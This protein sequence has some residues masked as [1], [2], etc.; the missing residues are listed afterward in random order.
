MRIEKDDL[1]EAANAGLISDE[2]AIR[3]WAF[4]S[5]MQEDIP[6]FQLAHV[7][8]YFG[9]LLA[10]TA[11]TLFVTQAW[12]SLIGLPL[13]VL[14]ICLGM[15]GCAFTY[16]FINKKLLIPAG[17]MSTFTLVLVPLAVYNVQVWLGLI[18]GKN[19]EYSDYHYWIN[20]YW[21]PIELITLLVGVVMLYIYRFPF[22]LFPISITLWYM[23][24]DLYSLLFNM[25]GYAWRGNFTLIFGFLYIVLAIYVDFRNNDD[26]KDYAFWLYIFAVLTFWSGLTYQRSDN[27][28]TQFLYCLINLGMV[29]TSVLLNR[30]VFAVF[31]VIGVIGYLGHLSFAVFANSLGFP[32]ALVILGFVIIFA[33]THWPKIEMKLIEYLRPYI[34]DKILKRL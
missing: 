9:G 16:Y 33:A 5:K 27:E 1:K 22:L 24:M 32:I 26:K 28:L 30:R 29:F 7:M 18:P 31:G 10:I 23:S 19:F 2:Q 6:R 8:Y 12:E 15:L 3:L 34:P 11:V 14:S 4:W 13:F 25:E 17:I 20:W 21:V